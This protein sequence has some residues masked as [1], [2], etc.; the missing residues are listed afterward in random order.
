MNKH[1]SNPSNWLHSPFLLILTSLTLG[2]SYWGDARLTLAQET[3]HFGNSALRP[4]FTVQQGTLSGETGGTS[5][6]AAISHYDTDGHHLCSGYTQDATTPDH[7][8]ELQDQFERLT[9]RVD[10]RGHDTTL[11]IQG[12]N[13]TIY[14]G[15]DKSDFDQDAQV[16]A[17]NLPKGTYEVWVGT[18]VPGQKQR[19]RLQ[20]LE[21]E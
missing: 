21:T 11:V 16:S 12:P 3:S 9:L 20:V 1:R 8:L 10:S 6:L 5:S 18:A 4:G 7:I 17:I 14:C 19:Y 2:A 15:D 13:Q